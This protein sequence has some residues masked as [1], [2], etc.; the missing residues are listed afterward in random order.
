M[1]CIDIRKDKFGIAFK[2]DCLE[3]KKGYP[4]H[5]LK[6][7]DNTGILTVG[8]M[9]RV[10]ILRINNEYTGYSILAE[11]DLGILAIDD[12]VMIE[13]RLYA[14]DRDRKKLAWAVLQPV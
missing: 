6:V 12:S 2:F 14:V 8:F 1:S 5:S 13:N 10:L 3:R 7:H 9:E 11:L 4:I